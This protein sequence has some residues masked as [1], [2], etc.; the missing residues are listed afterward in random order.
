MSTP[1]PPTDDPSLPCFLEEEYRAIA[2][3]LALVLDCW[4]DLK[5]KKTHYL[6][7]EEAEPSKAYSNR[8][9]RTRFD[10]R[11]EPAIR[12][13]AGLLSSFKLTDDSPQSLQDAQENIDLQGND[14]VAFWQQLDEMCLRDGGVGILVEY[15]TA[16]PGIESKGDMLRSGRR[17]YLVSVDRRNILNWETATVNGVVVLQRV[18]IREYRKVRKGLFGSETKPFYRVMAPGYWAIYTV[19]SGNS[20][21]VATLQEE[22]ET[23]LETIPMIWYSTTGTTEWFAGKPPF[24]NLAGLNVEHFQK[25]SS[26]NEVMHKCN[27]P[28]PVRKGYIRPMQDLKAVPRLIIGPNSVVDVPDNG[29]FGFAE[30][31]GAAIG[32]TQADI[33]KLEDSMDRVS[34]A[35]LNGGEREKTA[36]EAILDTAQI[37]CSVRTMARRKENAGWKVASLWAAYTKES[38]PKNGAGLEVNE[39]ILK[40]PANP[41]DVQLILDSMGIKFSS[42]LGLEMLLHRNWLPP[43]TD[44]EAELQLLEAQQ[45]QEAEEVLSDGQ[46]IES[47][48]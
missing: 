10:N 18:T 45:Q 26:L 28:V 16:D 13:H 39:S 5:G 23:D 33:I 9:E 24:I 46:T 44:I 4:N 29:D 27:L 19:E 37:Q 41:Q 8:L 35:F 43:E 40:P 36:T 11:F 34:L 12:G 42:K 3:D 21:W 17:P 31:T 25:R 7:Q 6:P 32:A 14:A 30:P 22:G 38:E 20:G 47:E 15:P 48:G 1:N 2:D